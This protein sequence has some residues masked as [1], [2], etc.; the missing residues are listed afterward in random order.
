MS[1]VGANDTV[2]LAAAKARLFIQR[3]RFAALDGEHPSKASERMLLHMLIVNLA[4]LE[5]RE[6]IVLAPDDQQQAGLCPK[7]QA[8]ISI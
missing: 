4:G 6:S 8:C 1:L 7:R 5:A 3:M 2:P